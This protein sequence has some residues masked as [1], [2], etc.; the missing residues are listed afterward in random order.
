MAETISGAGSDSAPQHGQR[1]IGKGHATAGVQAD[2]TPPSVRAL[3]ILAC[4]PSPCRPQCRRDSKFVFA[5]RWTEAAVPASARWKAGGQCLPLSL[6]P[7]GYEVSPV[8]R[9]QVAARPCP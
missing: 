7:W 8:C 4:R 2:C 9:C 5:V 3:G 6:R 1:A